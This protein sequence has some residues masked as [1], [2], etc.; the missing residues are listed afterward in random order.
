MIAYKIVEEKDAGL[1]TLYHG[2]NGSRRLP[3]GEWLEADE[4]LVVDGSGQTPYLSGFHVFTTQSAAERYLPRFTAERS[5]E[6]V[7]VEV[8][9]TRPKPT[10]GDVLLAAKMRIRGRGLDASTRVGYRFK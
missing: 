4:R 5:L 3:I 7:R 1:F 10:N 2:V 8:G 6:I 9:E